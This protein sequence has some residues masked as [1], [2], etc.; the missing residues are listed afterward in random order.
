MA[1]NADSHARLGLQEPKLI[2]WLLDKIVC[3]FRTH[4]KHATLCLA[5]ALLL[6]GLA[7]LVRSRNDNRQQSCQTIG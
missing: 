3:L 7:A 6:N 4:I 5:I 1:T 2:P